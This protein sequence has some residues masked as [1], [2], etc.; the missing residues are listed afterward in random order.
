MITKENI[1]FNLDYAVRVGLIEIQDQINIDILSPKEYCEVANCTQE[2]AHD[3][4]GRFD[5]ILMFSDHPDHLT[6]ESDLD[7]DDMDE[8][9]FNWFKELDL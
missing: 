3:I 7:I 6:L 2:E 9:I 4:W 1:I 5:F 8:L